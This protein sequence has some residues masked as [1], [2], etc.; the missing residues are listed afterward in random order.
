M[1]N[2][3]AFQSSLVGL[4]VLRQFYLQRKANSQKEVHGS[5]WEDISTLL[6]YV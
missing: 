4:V 5:L 1:E 3:L 6:N 2:K